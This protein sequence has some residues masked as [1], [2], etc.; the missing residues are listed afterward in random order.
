L[1]TEKLVPLPLFFTNYIYSK[2]FFTFWIAV[3]FTWIFCAAVSC[4]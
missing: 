4:V 1:L 3:S 2:P